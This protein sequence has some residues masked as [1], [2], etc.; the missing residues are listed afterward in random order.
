MLPVNVAFASFSVHT[1]VSPSIC[2]M[3]PTFLEV[4]AERCLMVPTF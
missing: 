4:T 3:L 2:P 1:L